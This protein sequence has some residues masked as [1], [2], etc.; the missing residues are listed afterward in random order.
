MKTNL[1]TLRDAAEQLGVAPHRIVYAIVSKK[2]PAVLVCS[3]RRMF[4]P[5]DIQ[6]LRAALQQPQKQGRRPNAGK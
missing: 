6:N 4:S 1:I 2:V 5:Q 3:G